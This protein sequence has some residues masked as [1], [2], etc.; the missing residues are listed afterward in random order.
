MGQSPTPEEVTGLPAFAPPTPGPRDPPPVRRHGV[1]QRPYGRMAEGGWVPWFGDEGEVGQGPGGPPAP[2]LQRIEG[3]HSVKRQTHS[4]ALVGGGG[5]LLNGE[6]GSWGHDIRTNL[7]QSPLRRED[8]EMPVKPCAGA[9]RHGYSLICGRSASAS[10]S[11]C[12]SHLSPIPAATKIVALLA[13]WPMPV[14]VVCVCVCVL[15]GGD[16]SAR[17]PPPV[18]SRVF[19]AIDCLDWLIFAAIS[20]LPVCSPRCGCGRMWVWRE[21]AGGRAGDIGVHV[22]RGRAAASPR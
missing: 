19:G 3:Q 7:I 20:G 6:P 11:W 14:A 18:H 1:R 12:S 5:R 21:R 4:S 16:R 8:G 10:F 15:V 22:A 17:E 13:D 2:H 9:S